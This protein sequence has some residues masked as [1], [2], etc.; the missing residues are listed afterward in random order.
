MNLTKILNFIGL[1]LWIIQLVFGI[2]AMCRM[3]VI[4]PLAY[5]GAVIICIMHYVIELIGVE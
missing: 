2:M 4:P 1:V 5:V 3:L